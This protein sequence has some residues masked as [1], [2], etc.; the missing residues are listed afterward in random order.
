MPLGVWPVPGDCRGPGSTESG[1]AASMEPH[2][3]ICGGPIQRRGWPARRRV[4]AC[5][6]VPMWGAD[7]L[8]RLSF[9][10]AQGSRTVS[11]ALWEHALLGQMLMTNEVD[12]S[13]G[14]SDYTVRG[15]FAGRTIT[16][17][18]PDP[19][20]SHCP[21]PAL[22]LHPC[23]ET[24]EFLPAHSTH[25][26]CRPSS[27]ALSRFLPPCPGSP[28]PRLDKV[29]IDDETGVQITRIIGAFASRRGNGT[30][31]LLSSLLSILRLISLFGLAPG[32]AKAVSVAVNTER[33]PSSTRGLPAPRLTG[34]SCTSLPM[35]RASWASSVC[36]EPTTTWPRPRLPA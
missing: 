27:P 1:V 16:P 23:R 9:A 5:S 33:A 3:S 34:A 25:S 32:L 15:G 36:R 7:R 31:S 8:F 13:M 2:E 21:V 20:C 14:K 4:G 22:H 17:A 24:P 26:H 30:P 18:R 6:R 11:T 35:L 10:K 19:C 12:S 28:H 29:D